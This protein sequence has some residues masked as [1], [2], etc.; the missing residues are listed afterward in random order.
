[1]ARKA[2]PMRL[3]R[4]KG[5]LSPKEVADRVGVTREAVKQHM[6]NGNLR[7]AKAPNGYWW[8]READ[9]KAFIKRRDKLKFKYHLRRSPK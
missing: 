6:Y 8:V 2:V 7:A 4:P 3:V 1:M 5:C 9:L